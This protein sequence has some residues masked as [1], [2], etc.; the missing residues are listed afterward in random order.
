MFVWF[1]FLALIRRELLETLRRRRAFLFLALV[2]GLSL[3]AVLVA[4]PE[5]ETRVYMGG[6]AAQSLMSA[7]LLSLMVSGLLLVP[8]L[9]GSAIVSERVNDSYDQLHLTLIRPSGILAAKLANVLGFYFLLA[10]A[11]LPLGGVLFFLVGIEWRDCLYGF[12]LVFSLVFSCASAGLMC[13]TLFQRTIPAI[14]ASYVAMIACTGLP[15]VLALAC[16]ESFFDYNTWNYWTSQ[17]D[18]LFVQWGLAAAPSRYGGFSMEF[19]LCSLC[20][21]ISLFAPSSPNI[22]REYVYLAGAVIQCLLALGFLVVSASVLARAPRPPKVQSERP[23][24]DTAILDSRRKNFPFYLIDPLRRKEQI[25][26]GR[27]AFLIK[28]IRWGL[29][30]RT[31]SLMRFFYASLLL[32]LLG[33]P[34]VTIL[35]G[36]SDNF[37]VACG[38]AASMIL[39]LLITPALLS[40]ALIKEEEQGNL[41]MVRMTLLSPR[42][43]LWGKLQA[44]AMNVLFLLIPAL[45]VL[46]FVGA[47]ESMGWADW[48]PV[49]IT[50]YAAPTLLVC[51][52]VSLAASMCASLYAHST[53]AAVTGSYAL[54]GFLLVGLPLVAAFVYVMSTFSREGRLSGFYSLDDAFEPPEVCAFSPWVAFLRMFGER[55]GIVHV[56]PWLGS[57]ALFTLIAVALLIHVA[58]RYHHK[59]LKG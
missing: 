43:I 54:S 47:S 32:N 42:E 39:T 52:L 34:L 27:N 48:T 4:W 36:A 11:V 13:S 37:S 55:Q 49:N 22:V 31:T 41:D 10:V 5:E 3:L 35:M 1:P 50:L 30:G 8:G 12:A 51:A 15:V 24:D 25:S 56:Y 7:L 28:E 6:F 44:G 33:V 23:I 9:A 40:N 2:C 29:L 45:V 57:L 46:L 53:G 14:V 58:I 20:P 21:P 38:A 59:F 18:S 17:L 19:L 16:L 26:D